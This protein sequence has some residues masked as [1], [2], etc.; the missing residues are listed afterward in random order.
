M[1]VETDSPPAGASNGELIRWAFAQ[2]NKRDVAPLMRFWT[3]ESVQRFPDKTCRGAE[4]IAAYFEV[5]FA[6]MPDWNMQVIDLIEQGEH[7]FVQWHLSGTHSGDPYQGIEATG[8]RIELDGMDHFVMHDG[9]TVSN[10]V[11]FDQL[12]F[13]RQIGFVPED[14]TPSDRTAKAAFN[15]KNRIQR[16][17][18]IL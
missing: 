17:L 15:A 18:K 11:I 1:T 4:E 16:K 12:Q 8:K 10:L 2:L 7:V 14:G 9:K 3:D 13:A 5:A 6:A